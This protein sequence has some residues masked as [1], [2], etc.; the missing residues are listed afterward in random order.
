MHNKMKNHG[1]LT[2]TIEISH[3]AVLHAVSFSISDVCYTQGLRNDRGLAYSAND[4]AYGCRAECPRTPQIHV[5]SHMKSSTSSL[6]QMVRVYF[7][8]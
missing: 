3:D 1:H 4:F 5:I 8:L 6:N 2:L 7:D